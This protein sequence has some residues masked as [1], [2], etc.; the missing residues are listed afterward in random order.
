MDNHTVMAALDMLTRIFI[1]G[2]FAWIISVERRLS[3]LETQM[4]F[5]KNTLREV[6]E[7]CQGNRLS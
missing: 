5:I 7:L 6:K 3:K 2:I 4:K 1:F